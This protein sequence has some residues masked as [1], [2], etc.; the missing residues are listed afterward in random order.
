MRI[1]VD[2]ISVL[3]FLGTL[4]VGIMALPQDNSITYD[5]ALYIN[6][7]RSL[8]ED[9]TS[10]T[11]QGVYMMYR[12]PLYPYTLSLFFRVISSNHL[13]I[14]RLVSVF[15]FAL[16]SALVYLLTVEMFGNP[17]EGVIASLFYALNPLAFTMAG[18]EL[19]HSEF[20]FFYTSCYFVIITT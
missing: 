10:F 16:T 6:I 14:A 13:L 12:P 19:V 11:Y 3:V 20:T 7:A 8:A 15:S 18:R 17:V 1:K 4:I 5:G 2:K 9:I